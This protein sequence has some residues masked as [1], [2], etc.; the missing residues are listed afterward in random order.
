MAEYLHFSRDSRLYMEKDGYLWS[1][2]VLDGFSFSQATNASEI[3]LNEMEDSSGRS[4]RGR[5]MFT[6]SLSAAEWSFATYARPFLA[7][8]GVNEDGT[9]KANRN[10]HAQVH[11][12]EEALWVAMAGRNTYTA[13]TGRWASPAAGGAISSFALGGLTEGNG[14]TA[15]TTP[16]TYTVSNSTLGGS[17]TGASTNSTNGAN[18]VVTLTLTDDGDENKMMKTVVEYIDIEECEFLMIAMYVKE[19]Q[20]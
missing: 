2:P 11:A 9:G 1:I 7:A 20:G 13:T 12:V 17:T 16:Y 8:A 19:N 6:D 3:T 4:R 15:S 10:T 5:K 18:A 14:G